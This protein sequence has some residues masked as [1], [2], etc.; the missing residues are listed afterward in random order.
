M[1][2]SFH[3]NI[4]CGLSLPAP[5]VTTLYNISTTCHR[6]LYSGI[7]IIYVQSYTLTI[8]MCCFIS[9]F[10]NQNQFLFTDLKKSPLFGNGYQYPPQLAAHIP[11]M[12]MGHPAMIN[13]A[14]YNHLGMRHPEMMQGQGVRQGA[15]TDLTSQ[16]CVSYVINPD[17]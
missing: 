13:L 7:L 6:P 16:R 4:D 11:F 5:N 17:L 12:P 9:F 1:I 10:P 3:L 2:L 15:P 14:M 8:N